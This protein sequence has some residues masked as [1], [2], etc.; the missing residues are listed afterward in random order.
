M[1]IFLMLIFFDVKSSVWSKKVGKM[2]DT[3]ILDDINIRRNYKI[4]S[5]DNTERIWAHRF[6]AKQTKLSNAHSTL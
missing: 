3:S 1:Q 6:F 2:K 5:G 4:G